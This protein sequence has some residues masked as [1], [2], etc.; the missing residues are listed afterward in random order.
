M[1]NRNKYD[2]ITKDTNRDEATFDIGLVKAAAESI[3]NLIVDCAKEKDPSIQVE[4]AR[5]ISMLTEALTKFDF[6]IIS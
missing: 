6:K 4:R 3:L 2:S 5:A 1:R